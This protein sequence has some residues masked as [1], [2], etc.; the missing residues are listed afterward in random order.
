[1]PEVLKKWLRS[2]PQNHAE[3][4]WDWLDA[5]PEATHRMIE[6]IA[7]SHPDIPFI[8]EGDKYPRL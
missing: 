1:M 8:K 2:L 7:D 5:D 3:A 6:Q 4:L